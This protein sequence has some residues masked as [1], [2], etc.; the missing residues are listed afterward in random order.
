MISALASAVRHLIG[1]AVSG[2]L[3]AGIMTGD[4]VEALINSAVGLVTVIALVAWSYIEKKYF[5][6]G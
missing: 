4:Q 5:K 2:L 6:K 1:M 3:A